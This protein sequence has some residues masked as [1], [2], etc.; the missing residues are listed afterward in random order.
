[1]GRANANFDQLIGDGA[2]VLNRIS[3]K[4]TTWF[5]QNRCGVEKKA[6]NAALFPFASGDTNVW[7]SSFKITTRHT[8]F[9]SQCVTK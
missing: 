9:I 3:S 5:S 4:T 2:L 7:T 6:R 8:L 1:M